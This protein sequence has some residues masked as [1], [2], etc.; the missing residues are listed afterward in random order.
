MLRIPRLVLGGGGIVKGT[1]Y[2]VADIN[3]GFW[4]GGIFKGILYRVAD[5]NGVR[6]VVGV[7][8]R[9]YCILSRMPRVF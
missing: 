8:L 9:V 2:R 6:W 3:G 7:L 4:G 1:L 5:T